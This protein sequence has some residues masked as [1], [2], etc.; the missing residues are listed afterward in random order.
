MEMEQIP[1]DGFDLLKKR[2]K[3]VLSHD[4]KRM[5]V[6]HA[7]SFLAEPGLW[8]NYE[9]EALAKAETMLRNWITEMSKIPGWK[10]VIKRRKYTFSMLF[11]MVT[12]DDYEQKKHAK[13][14]R[15]WTNLFRYYSSRVQKGGSINGR[16]YSKTIYTIS[17][18]RLNRPPYSVRLRIPWMAE[19]G[20]R[21]DER[22]MHCHETD[23]LLPGHARN[24][25]TDAN[26]K[27][28]SEEAKRRYNERYKD[29]KH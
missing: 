8:E 27:R 29:R 10:R 5:I 6:G 11:K 26:M 2:E 9:N 16:T 24:P 14:I 22:T 21:P 18:K 3:Q 25:N 12:G 20:M 15:M 4:P 19:H 17:P 13:E 7:E 28:R 1:T 23:V